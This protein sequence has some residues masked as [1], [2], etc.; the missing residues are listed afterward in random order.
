MQRVQF[1]FISVSGSLEI[2]GIVHSVLNLIDHRIIRRYF[3]LIT[4]DKE[5]VFLYL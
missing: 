1:R 2:S 4:L 3:L 5:I